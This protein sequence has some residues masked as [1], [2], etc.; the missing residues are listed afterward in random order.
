NREEVLAKVLFE[1]A[2]PIESVRR[3]LPEGLGAIVRRAM[4]RELGARFPSIQ[5]LRLALSACGA[6]ALDRC[7]SPSSVPLPLDASAAACGISTVRV[8]PPEVTP[9]APLDAA[10]AASPGSTAG[11]MTEGAAGLRPHS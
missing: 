6:A 1:S 4:A 3:D 8:A 2:A 11:L 7:D 10:R 5:E 9:G